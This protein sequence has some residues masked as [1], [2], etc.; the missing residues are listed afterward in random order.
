VLR[1]AAPAHLA[2]NQKVSG[3]RG[4]LIPEPDTAAILGRLPRNP[5]PGRGRRRDVTSIT[6]YINRDPGGDINLKAKR[7]WEILRRSDNYPRDWDAAFAQMVKMLKMVMDF[8]PDAF[9]G[10]QEAEKR[11]A[12]MKKMDPPTWKD[13]ADK[14]FSQKWTPAKLQEE[15]LYSDGG[16]ALADKYGLFLPYHYDDPL[17][18]PLKNRMRLV[19]S[20]MLSVRIITQNPTLYE[21][22]PNQVIADH[23]PHL[24]DGRF[25]TIEIDLYEKQG[26]IQK[27]IKSQLDFYQDLLKQPKAK[28]RDRALDFYL[29][30][31]KG[32]VSIY[33]L[34]DM[35][36]KGGKS[37]WKITQIKYPSL[38]DGKSYQ[39][40]SNNYDRTV[41]SRWKQ[42]D[43]G[44]KRADREIKSPL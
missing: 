26:V 29:E 25:L 3:D 44:I 6:K 37:P 13:F 33:E 22:G 36:K 17:W 21:I 11:R 18:D 23:T 2:V 42:I 39:P 27:L 32:K 34:W 9:G 7:R 41:R 15:F 14:Q 12:L 4:R 24:R 31:E 20:D 40:A 19:F 16:K 38:T 10:E 1:H 5:S 43:D 8:G 28:K 30:T 35:K